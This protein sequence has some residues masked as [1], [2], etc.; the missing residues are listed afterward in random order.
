MTCHCSFLLECQ[1]SRVATI[2]ATCL[3]AAHVVKLTGSMHSRGEIVARTGHVVYEKSTHHFPTWY[4]RAMSSSFLVDSAAALDQDLACAC[5]PVSRAAPLC[6]VAVPSSVCDHP[7]A[8]LCTACACLAVQ[9]LD[10]R[11]C[12]MTCTNV[13]LHSRC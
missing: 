12:N 10:S 4:V 1:A 6:P 3:L 7:A 9:S 13:A 11:A 5:V 2:S 8:M